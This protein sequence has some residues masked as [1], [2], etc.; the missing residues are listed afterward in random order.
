MVDFLSIIKNN[1]KP[2]A[3]QKWQE[4]YDIMAVHT[5]ANTPERIFKER[6]PLE[7]EN[8]AILEFRKKNHRPI[9]VNEFQKAIAD[10]INTAMSIDIVVNYNGSDIIDYESELR[11]NTGLNKTN[12]KEWLFKIVGA[13]RQTDPNAV[14]VFLPQHRSEKFIPSFENEIPNFDSKQQLIQKVDVLPM[15]VSSK[16]IVYIDVDNILFHAGDYIYNEDGKTKPYYYALNKDQTFVIIPKEEEKKNIYEQIPLYNNAISIAPFFAIGGKMIIEQDGAELK[17]YYISDYHGA[18]A[19]GDLAIGQGSDLRVCEIRF[20]YPRHWRIKVKCDNNSCNLIDGIYTDIEHN[21][22]CKRCNGTGYIQDTTPM[23]TLMIDKGGTLLSDDGKFTEPEGFIAPPSEILKHSAE[24]E[25]FYFGKMLQS[26]CVLQQNMTNQSGESKSYDVQHKIDVV[27]SIVYDLT[28][29]YAT[30]LEIIDLYRGGEGGITITLPETLDVRNSNDI[31]TQLTEAKEKGAP[32]PA[33]VELTKKFMLKNFGGDF[34][35]KFVVEFL[36]NTDKLFALSQSELPNAKAILGSDINAKD[37]IYHNMGYATL[38][39]MV[40]KDKS[41]IDKEDNEI[42]QMLNEK[43][44]AF[45]ATSPT[46]II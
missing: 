3:H 37:I 31:L 18:A 34:I 43:L 16:N 12:L 35:N 24:R 13:Y 11:I 30:S 7:S 32:Y 14:V 4:V 27:S 44:S 10:Y 46:T 38:K 45:I 29:M 25:S 36:A 28:N 22:T 17:S 6:R 42:M 39:K 9:T 33:Q 15:L 5:Q 1:S 20:V 23:G 19:W 21:S 2:P 40:E 26:L 8:E 41:I